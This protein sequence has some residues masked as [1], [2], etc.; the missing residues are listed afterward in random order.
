[1]ANTPQCIMYR[2][3]AF[4]CP[5]CDEVRLAIGV[6]DHECTKCKGVFVSHDHLRTVICEVMPE[7]Q[8]QEYS[9]IALS[10]D[11]TEQLQLKCPRCAAAMLGRTFCGQTLMPVKFMAFGLTPR[12]SRGRVR[13]CWAL[14]HLI[15][16]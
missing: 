4:Q 9:F 8:F 3:S 11:S 15:K 14:G 5:R 1:M 7:Y 12:N 16:A 2:D 6:Q 10:Q 13:Q